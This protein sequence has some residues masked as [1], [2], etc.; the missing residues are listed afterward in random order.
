MTANEHRDSA[1]KSRYRWY[2]VWDDGW[3]AFSVIVAAVTGLIA[4]LG[5]RLFP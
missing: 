3:L 5:W 1:D 4:Y 2:S